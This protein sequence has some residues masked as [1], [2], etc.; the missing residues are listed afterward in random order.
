MGRSR[1]SARSEISSSGRSL[2]RSMRCDAANDTCPS[3]GPVRLRNDLIKRNRVLLLHTSCKN[4]AA[5][6]ADRTVNENQYASNARVD[7]F[8][9]CSVFNSF[10]VKVERISYM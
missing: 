1:D 3:R 8:G 6:I 4:K 7:C 2:S 9:E 10:R 5:V